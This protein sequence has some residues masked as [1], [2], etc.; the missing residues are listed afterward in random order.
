M[1]LIS[2]KRSNT[3]FTYLAMLLVFICMFP[4]LSLLGL[5]QI[6]SQPNDI[7]LCV[8]LFPFIKWKKAPTNI[9]LLVLVSMFAI[10]VVLISPKDFN[11]FRSV[12]N[13]FAVFFV[14]LL[15]YQM[16][17]HLTFE[18]FKN[19]LK[20]G[21]LIWFFV[22]TVQFVYDPNFLSFLLP[23]QS[24]SFAGGRGI[25][26]MATEP[27][28]Y[29]YALCLILC[30][31][32]LIFKGKE[33]VKWTALI[34]LQVI[35]YSLSTTAIAGLFLVTGIY[36][37]FSSAKVRN[38]LFLAMIPIGL[39]L[40]YFLFINTSFLEAQK[41]NTRIL[42]IVYLAIQNPE[43]ILI[44]DG[45]GNRRFLAI[46]L[47]IYGSFESFFIP[48]GYGHFNDYIM[49]PTIRQKFSSV[50]SWLNEYGR[51]QSSIGAI[52]FELGFMGLV[53]IYAIVKPFRRIGTEVSKF[54]MIFFIFLLLNP[55]PFTNSIVH[56]VIGVVSFLAFSPGFKKGVLTT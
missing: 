8:F 38:T 47:S 9:L 13:Y 7:I 16:L 23:H 3:A 15:V 11:T 44:L 55:V 36:F 12:V 2:V 43:A 25:T 19:V 49:S 28:Y 56:L 51:I 1:S 33:R 42:N 35:L 32:L 21:L 26:S 39:I 50:I 22:G 5:H 18:Q 6:G 53:A 46:F 4:N 52:L 54:S 27:T 20:L 10:G 34:L 31:T 17:S 37:I 24:G 41:E 48:H 40:Y 45:S 14:P 29:A 30:I